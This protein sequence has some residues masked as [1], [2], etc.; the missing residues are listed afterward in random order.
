MIALV[1]TIVERVDHRLRGT[2]IDEVLSMDEVPTV[3]EVPRVVIDFSD[4]G[5]P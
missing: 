2:S 3:N 1:D 5:H 4:D